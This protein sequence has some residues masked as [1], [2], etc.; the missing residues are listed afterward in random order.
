MSA[1]PG[2]VV[3]PTEVMPSI[4]NGPGMTTPMP[5]S[6]ALK[7]LRTLSSSVRRCAMT[8]L[9]LV[10]RTGVMR[11]E[12]GWPDRSSTVATMWSEAISMPMVMAPSG[13]TANWIGGWPRPERRRPVSINRFSLTSSSTMLA[14]ACAV[15]WVSRAICIRPS[16]P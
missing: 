9:G 8:W 13:L 14:I 16:E 1:Q 12:R 15:R 2:R 11:F 3:G 5:S 4:S 10:S 6:G 7:S